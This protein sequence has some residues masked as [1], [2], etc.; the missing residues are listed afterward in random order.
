MHEVGFNAVAGQTIVTA[1]PI[2]ITF[3]VI[4]IFAIVAAILLSYYSK[5]RTG[6]VPQ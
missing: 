1:N 6:V 5:K 3:T 2:W 4:V